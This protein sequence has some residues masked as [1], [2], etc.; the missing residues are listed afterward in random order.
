MFHEGHPQHAPIF[1]VILIVIVIRWR[2]ETASASPAARNNSGSQH[3]GHMIPG[4]I[5]RI[6]IVPFWIG[7]QFSAVHVGTFLNYSLPG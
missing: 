4:R 1:A 2:G 3:F 5:I 7:R 6:S